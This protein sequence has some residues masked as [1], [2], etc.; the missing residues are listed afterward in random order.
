M[1][2]LLDM[3][4]L[5]WWLSGDRKLG[6][7]ALACMDSPSDE[8]LVSIVSLWEIML[9]VSGHN[10]PSDHLL[11]AQAINEDAIFVSDDRWVPSYAVGHLT[12]SDP[13]QAIG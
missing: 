9:T 3:H 13:P 10:D 4:A 11:I 6:S 1:R 12:C 5:L 8:V 7:R 2:L